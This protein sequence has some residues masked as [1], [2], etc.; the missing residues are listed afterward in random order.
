MRATG[1]ESPSLVMMI[2]SVVLV[3]LSGCFS[4]K[5][6]SAPLPELLARPEPPHIV[7]GNFQMEIT[8]PRID[9]GSLIGIIPGSDSPRRGIASSQIHEVATKRLNVGKTALAVLGPPLVFPSI[10]SMIALQ[11]FHDSFG[12]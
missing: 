12:E 5:V 11:D 1:R 7:P 3:V 4:W 2:P 9:G 6:V 10:G 8:Q